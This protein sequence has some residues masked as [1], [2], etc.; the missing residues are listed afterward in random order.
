MVYLTRTTLSLNTDTLDAIAHIQYRFFCLEGKKRRSS[1]IIRIAIIYLASLD[2]DY[3]YSLFFKY[4]DLVKWQVEKE[5]IREKSVMLSRN[6]KMMLTEISHNLKV[7]YKVYYSGMI[8]LAIFLLY[9]EKNLHL[10]DMD[11]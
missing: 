7:G 2:S 5:K 1:S 6:S 8:R 3:V 10:I 4:R 9:N 11:H